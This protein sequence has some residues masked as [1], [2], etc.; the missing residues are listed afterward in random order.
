MERKSKA[1][2]ERKSG[3][4]FVLMMAVVTAVLAIPGFSYFYFVQDSPFHVSAIVGVVTGFFLLYTL[5][6]IIGAFA[7]GRKAIT[8]LAKRGD[9]KEEP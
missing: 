4:L 5:D 9:E 8:A 6:I 1:K 7:L 2:R 3:L